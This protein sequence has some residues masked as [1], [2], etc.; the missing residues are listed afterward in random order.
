LSISAPVAPEIVTA[1][2]TGWSSRSKIWLPSRVITTQ[3]PS[4]R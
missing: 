3:S 4:S 1:R 2:S